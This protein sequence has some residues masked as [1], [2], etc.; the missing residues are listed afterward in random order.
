[1]IATTAGS[2]DEAGASALFNSTTNNTIS[3]TVVCTKKYERK[4]SI[5]EIA[6]VIRQELLNYPEI[7]RS[8]VR[9]QGGMGGGGT[10]TVDVEIYGYSFDETNI[11]AEEVR[12]Q[13]IDKVST[14]RDVTISRDKDRPELNLVIDKEKASSFGLNAATV[15]TYVHNRVGGQAAGFLKE[16]GEE[17]DI[18]VRLREADR[19]SLDDIRNLSIPTTTGRI[20]KLSEISTVEEYFAPPTI[21]R[22]SRQRYL[23]VKSTPYNTS[24]GQ[25]AGEIQTVIDQ[26]RIPEGISMN[27]GGDVEDQQEMFGDI[28]SLALLII[29]L[30]YVVMASQFE[31]FSKPAI[32]ML[33]VPFA[34]T[35]VIL[36]LWIT[37][38][39]LDMIGAL[40]V[41]MLIGIVVK[42]GIVLVDYINLMRE[43]GYELSEAIA[44]SGRSR[45]RPVLMTA[46]TT[47]LGML[48]MA[49]SRGEGSEM[50]HPLGIVVIG[51]LLVSTFVTLIV[52]PVFYAVLSKQD[53][54]TKEEKRRKNFIF[55]QLSADDKKEEE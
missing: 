46:L 12:Q 19:N 54:K 55:M 48:P 39:P 51:G 13:I 14:A 47:I 9:D 24:L 34:I 32:I 27:I 7:V 42:N 30:V 35:G 11:L 2:T 16:D 15:S 43:R 28:I 37:G 26:I 31:S 36:A 29:L 41:V 52:V 23:T 25:L 33:A 6:E 4:R 49:L 17:Y 45:L 38:T 1:M 44:L 50:W 22:K 20:I 18:V 3:M 40:G 21:D 10:S 5:S 8:T 53:E